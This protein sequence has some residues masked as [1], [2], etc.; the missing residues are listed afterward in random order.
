MTAW[1]CGDD[2]GVCSVVMAWGCGGMM[3]TVDCSILARV[4]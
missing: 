3:V 1:G 4:N 2:L